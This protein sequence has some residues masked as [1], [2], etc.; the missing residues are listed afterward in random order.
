MK[1]TISYEFNE[2]RKKYICTTDD[3]PSEEVGE[4]KTEKEADTF[5]NGWNES[6]EFHHQYVD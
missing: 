3:I 6:I 1:I 4:F 5:C 2:K